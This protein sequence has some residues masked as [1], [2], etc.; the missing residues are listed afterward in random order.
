MSGLRGPLS[1]SEC[2]RVAVSQAPGLLTSPLH[3]PTTGS[4]TG[5]TATAWA[6][7]CGPT[8]PVS[9]AC[10]TLAIEK[11][12]APCTR[13]QSFSRWGAPA[14]R[15][16]DGPCVWRR[17]AGPP[18]SGGAGPVCVEV[19]GG[20]CVCGGEG[21]GQLFLDGRGPRVQVSPVFRVLY[22]KIFRSPG[23]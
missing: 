2:L 16:G 21:Q 17:G 7:T 5:I 8:A 15:Q 6:P 4:F 23:I 14:A 20:A 13:R 10:F 3:R 12:M 22:K 1:W 18:V 19:R 11:A 9:R